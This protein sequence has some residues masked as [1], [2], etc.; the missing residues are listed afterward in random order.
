MPYELKRAKVIT[1]KLKLGNETLTIKINPKEIAM[2]YQG[3][4]ADLIKAQDA[5]RAA[6]GKPGPDLLGAYGVVIINLFEVLFGAENGEKILKFYE[7][8]FDEMSLMVFPFIV[9]QIKPQLDRVIARNRRRARKNYKKAKYGN[10]W[11]LG[12][13]LKK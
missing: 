1:K 3:A 6:G 8:N 7:G 13:K 4:E 10:K 2:A 12:D 9:K 5:V 11:N